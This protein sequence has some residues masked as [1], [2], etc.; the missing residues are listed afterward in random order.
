MTVSK[1]ASRIYQTAK[2]WAR[3]IGFFFDSKQE[4]AKAMKTAWR[5]L[6]FATSSRQDINISIAKEVCKTGRPHFY[7]EEQASFKHLADSSWVK[8]VNPHV[9]DLEGMAR[10]QA[11]RE[12]FSNVNNGDIRSVYL[13]DVFD[14]I[15]RG[16]FTGFQNVD[17]ISIKDT[18]I[19]YHV[20][21]E[22]NNGKVKTICSDRT[23]DYEDVLQ[24]DLRGIHLSIS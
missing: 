9:L 20:I 24:C 22:A 17:F 1:I 11:A 2:A 14:E 3:E 10:Q 6:K 4:W 8:P 16:L 12:L 5:R 23:L 19:N 13:G 7:N 15:P 18:R 21:D